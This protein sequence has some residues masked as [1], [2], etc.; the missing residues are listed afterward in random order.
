MGP[1]FNLL[2]LKETALQ[3]H[4]TQ[5]NCS[6]LECLKHKCVFLQG[7]RDGSILPEVLGQEEDETELILDSGFPRYV[8]PLIPALTLNPTPTPTLTTIPLPPGEEREMT[9]DE[10]EDEEEKEDVVEVNGREGQT[11][12]SY[13]RKPPPSWGEWERVNRGPVPPAPV[14]SGAQKQV[15]VLLLCSIVPWQVR[16][17]MSGFHLNISAGQQGAA[18]CA[19]FYS[20][21]AGTH[22]T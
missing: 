3:V 8:S 14:H 20:S 2:Q 16:R 15:N 22:Q 5:Y 18:V 1:Q 19:G 11:V 7:F 17:Q 4:S 10:E 13:P 21:P 6:T 12:D 9:V